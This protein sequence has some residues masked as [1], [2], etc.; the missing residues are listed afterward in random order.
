MFFDKEDKYA[1]RT[2]FVTE[3]HKRYTY[4]D[5][6]K[7]QD[8]MTDQLMPR[9]LVLIL[10]KNCVPAIAMHLGL[11]RKNMVPI[12]MDEHVTAGF[13]KEFMSAYRI[14]A[15]FLPENRRTEIR[16][17]EMLWN[18]EGYSLIGIRKAGPV[19]APE[20]AMLVPV[21]D[22]TGSLMM[23]RYSKEN[24]QAGTESA[25]AVQKIVGGDRLIT[26]L[27]FHF[28]FPLTILHSYILRGAQILVTERSVTERGF[29][30][31][32]HDE[33]ATALCAFPH[34]C[35]MLWRMHIDKMHIPG[36]RTL[37][38]SGGALPAALQKDLA[39]WAAIR[40][41]RLLIFYGKTESAG[42]MA[43]LGS[44]DSLKVLN[45][46][47]KPDA[48]G[49]MERVDKSGRPLTNGSQVGE[50][51]FYGENVSLGYAGS[52]DDLRRGDEH[53]GAL[54]TGDLAVCSEQ[55][56]YSIRGRS[57]RFLKVTGIRIDLD[58][59]E[60]LLKDRWKRNFAC[61]GTDD[62]LE[63]FEEARPVNELPV[64]EGDAG[65]DLVFLEVEEIKKGRRG[66][67]AKRGAGP[68][69][70]IPSA[71]LE[72]KAEETKEDG[73]QTDWKTT[74]PTIWAWTAKRL[75]IPKHMIRY[76]ICKEIPKEVQDAD[77]ASKGG[78]MIYKT[79]QDMKLSALGMGAMRLPVI[80]GDDSKIDKE[81]TQV[82]VD[83]AM[84]NGINYYDTAWGYH[85]GN[86]ELV[87]GEALKKYPRESFYLATKFP[88]YDLS[89]MP[90]VKEI[91]AKQLE[92]CQVEYF[93][94]YLVHNV[95]ELNIDAY[96]D[97]AQFGVVSYLREMK[98]EGKI[99]HLGFSAHG[100]VEVMKRFLDAYGEY[101]E[102]CQIQLNYLD[103]S[104]QDAKGKIELLKEWNLPIWVMEPLRGGRLAKLNDEE[105]KLL[106]SLRPEEKVPAWAFRFLQS[107]P[108]VTMILSGMSD[109]D[110]MK[111]NIDTF[112]TDAP[113][114]DNEWNEVLAMA[115][116]M[117]QTKTLPCTAC[118]Y[119]TSHCPQE[120]DIPW[121][122]ELYNEHGFTGGGFL[123]PMA[124][125][126]VPKDKRPSACIGCRSCEAV[127]PQQ[128]KISEAMADFTE[129]LKS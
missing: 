127:C 71:Q 60:R 19:M 58:E 67:R 57:E 15:V 106:A 108:E 66:R 4:Q 84:E 5:I 24:L 63:I 10:C 92:K 82:M 56:Y 50:I 69:R 94:F 128:I 13:L 102:F 31:F 11:L 110:Q 100:S 124:L 55:G 18:G 113:L 125:A 9:S 123:A 129:K 78:H 65:D 22:R 52:T 25:A 41:V 89:N 61:V 109:F 121:L 59:L 12:L 120:L 32:F 51:V 117:L 86:S 23:V 42:F 38:I 35:Q 99:R 46:I 114:S 37:A 34:T 88:G 81:Q 118:H 115:D 30:Q 3:S 77:N 27:P 73:M 107:I 68:I 98:K 26:N 14:N 83:Y 76:T 80:D 29:W 122:I 97:D 16:G 6:Y 87:M 54:K 40:G 43:H 17:G 101:M 8:Q 2:M 45:S 62:L 48:F 95:C 39:D 7:L 53:K 47:G 49:R 44:R 119:C 33:E 36:L 96:L 126:S 21:S 28:S 112:A 75:G 85:D 111:E 93:D 105:T 103:Y 20:L 104:F 90:K 74:N 91:F 70:E 116:R 79:F 64:N 72:D 1:Q